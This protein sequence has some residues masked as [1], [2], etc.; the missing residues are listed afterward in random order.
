VRLLLDTQ[1][2]LW[3]LTANPRLS[4]SSR[5]LI[6]ASP[7][8]VSVVSVWEV[9]LKHRIGKLAVPP[10]RFRDE[11][12]A[13][14]AAILSLTDQHVLTRIALPK[15]HSD[16]FD[17]LLLSVAESENL[18]LFTADAALVACA[19]DRRLPVRGA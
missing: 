13:A 9:D 18:M 8:T 16:P 10:E 17:R 1:V 14:G 4:R 7:C 5:E 11:M 2:A 3:W 12:R 19:S 15:T 6:A